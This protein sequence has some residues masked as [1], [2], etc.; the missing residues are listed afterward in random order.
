MNKTIS[1]IILATLGTTILA[2]PVLAATAISLSS[3]SINIAQG[4]NFNLVVAINPQGTNNYT[5]KAELQYPADLLEVR[6]F[7][8]ANNWM[9]LSQQGY[10]L[11][12][13]ENGLLIKTAGYPGGVSEPITFGTISFLAKQAGSGVIKVGDNSFVLDA[14]N[15]DVLN[16]TLAQTSVVIASP[17]S[18]PSPPDTSEPEEEV[19][20]EKEEEVITETIPTSTQTEEEPAQ[21]DEVEAEQYSETQET[22]FLA[23]IGNIL[24]LGTDNAWVSVFVGGI[25]L[26]ILI[27]FVQRFCRKK[28]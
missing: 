14:T 20:T 23:A 5:V 21:E 2:M 24:S 11:I 26:A 19:I 8:L 12:D 7:T 1:T 13:N 28:S 22:T 6:T 10:D 27:Y 4:Q 25:I 3:T 9:A 15:Q 17:I 18:E 16:S